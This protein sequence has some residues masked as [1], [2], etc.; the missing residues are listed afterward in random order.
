MVLSQNTE[1]SRSME[2]KNIET[3]LAPLFQITEMTGVDNF[4][5]HMTLEPNQESPNTKIRRKQRSSVWT[6]AKRL[7]N[8]PNNENGLTHA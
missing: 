6:H 3:T 4:D 7:R 5:P 2:S 8:H 1:E